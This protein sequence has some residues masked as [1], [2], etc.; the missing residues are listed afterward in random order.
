MLDKADFPGV[1]DVYRDWIGR[2][3]DLGLGTGLNAR[4]ESLRR[5]RD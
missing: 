3:W 5:V 4:Y 2:V 1:H